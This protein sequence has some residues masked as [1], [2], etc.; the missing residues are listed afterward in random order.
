[1]LLN[2]Y[3]YYMYIK[4]KDTSCTEWPCSSSS[5]LYANFHMATINVRTATDDLKLVQV[6]QLA[7]S[8][9]I[10]ILAKILWKFLSQSMTKFSSMTSSAVETSVKESTVW[11]W[12]CWG[13]TALMWSISSSFPTDLWA[14]T[15]VNLAPWSSWS[16][17]TDQQK[18]RLLPQKKTFVGTV[19]DCCIEGSKSAGCCNWR[20]KFNDLFIPGLHIFWTMWSRQEM[21]MCRI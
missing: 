15:S 10:I 19:K 16:W 3:A 12:R 14:W 13:P 11:H 21:K 8:R 4:H 7:A 17:C 20:L 1:M 18:V 2:D 5:K 6:I 9:N